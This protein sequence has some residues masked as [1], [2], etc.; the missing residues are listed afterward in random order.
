MQTTQA[1][2]KPN[3]LSGLVARK[4]EALPVTL[5]SD[6]QPVAVAPVV[7]TPAAATPGGQS[8]WKAMTLKF[9]QDRFVKLRTHCAQKNQTAQTI[10]MEA[11]D[12]WLEKN[13]GATS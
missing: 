5:P 1:T 2:N 4:G 8:Y 9:D 7:A 6:A 13:S 10:M 12:L 3:S 11:F